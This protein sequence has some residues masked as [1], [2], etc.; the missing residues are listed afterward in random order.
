MKQMVKDEVY[1]QMK[2]EELK[3]YEEMEAEAL[4]HWHKTMLET[5]ASWQA[6]HYKYSSNMHYVI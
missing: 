3:W 5:V 1:E 2:D 4:K 6:P